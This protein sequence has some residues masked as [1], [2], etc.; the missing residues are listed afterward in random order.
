MDASRCFLVDIETN[1][2]SHDCNGNI[3]M[4]ND[5]HIFLL[6][7]AHIFLRQPQGTILKY[8]LDWIK[9]KPVKEAIA[10]IIQWQSV[11][12]R[13]KRLRLVHHKSKS[14]CHK[15]HNTVASQKIKRAQYYP[16]LIPA[17]NK[18]L[19]INNTH[20]RFKQTRHIIILTQKSS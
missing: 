7:C 20:F 15:G 5:G 14:W 12:V 10:I 4:S 17:A 9:L 8:M 11:S 16:I 1:D 3:K 2:S 19:V 18:C 13:T 6:L